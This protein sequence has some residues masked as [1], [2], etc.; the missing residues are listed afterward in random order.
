MISSNKNRT[1]MNK[2]EPNRGVNSGS[3]VT[4]VMPH[5]KEESTSEAMGLCS[6][7]Y[8]SGDAVNLYTRLRVAGSMTTTRR[9][10]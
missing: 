2:P 6:L 3:L 1:R 4:I 7:M 9:D 5:D 10:G 8:H